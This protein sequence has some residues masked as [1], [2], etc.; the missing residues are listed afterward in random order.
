MYSIEYLKELHASSMAS[1]TESVPP[2]TE[3]D[4]DEDD[5]EDSGPPTVPWPQALTS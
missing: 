2:T 4:D 5:D 3:D 1:P